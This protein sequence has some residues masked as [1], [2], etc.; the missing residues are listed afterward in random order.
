MTGEKDEFLAMVSQELRPPL[1]AILG[2]TRM[3]GSS[4]VD[5]DGLCCK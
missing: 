2:Y 5:R 1:N 4:P 3:L